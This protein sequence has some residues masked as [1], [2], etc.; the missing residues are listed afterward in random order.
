MSVSATQS[1]QSVLLAVADYLG[2]P[3]RFLTV[4]D[5]RAELKRTLELASQSSV[6]LTTNGEPSAAIVSFETLEAVRSALVQMLVREMEHSFQQT[7]AQVES[8]PAG[9][10]T[11]EEE[12][13]ALVRESVRKARRKAAKKKTAVKTRRR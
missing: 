1:T 7:L 8:E 5:A 3:Q 11:S 13:E 6:V 4:A 9:E 12:L 10:P 2:R